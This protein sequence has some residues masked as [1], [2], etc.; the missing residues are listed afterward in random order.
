MCKRFVR[1]NAK[2]ATFFQKS[3]FFAF[4]CLLDAKISLQIVFAEI[5]G[6]KNGK[7]GMLLQ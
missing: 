1:K 7:K 4:F 3:T 2:K 5:V 6:S